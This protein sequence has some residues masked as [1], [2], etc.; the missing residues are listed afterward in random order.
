VQGAIA[1]S[2]LSFSRRR[3]SSLAPEEVSVVQ[4]PFAIVNTSDLKLF[5]DASLMSSERAALTRINVLIESNPAL[6]GKLQAV[7]AFESKG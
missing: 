5:D 3:K 4:E 6:R 2:D 1:K 7:P